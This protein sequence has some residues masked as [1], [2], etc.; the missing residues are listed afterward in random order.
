MADLLL[1]DIK[2]LEAEMSVQI[3]GQSSEKAFAMLDYCESVGKP[4][5]VRQV[6]LQ[7]F[8][9]DEEQLTKLAKKLAGYRCIERIELLPFHKLGEP[10][11]EDVDRPYTLRDTP[12]TTQEE[13][14]WAR[15]IFRKQ[16]LKVQ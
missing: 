13:A 10:K 6:L 11:W 2:A 4:V 9:L 16:G 12:A 5:W 3:S 7:G 8:T 15:E 14:E 1:L